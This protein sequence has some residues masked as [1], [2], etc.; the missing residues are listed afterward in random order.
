MLRSPHALLAVPALTY[1]EFL[2]LFLVIP[3]AGL[4]VLS[5]RRPA[6]WA[7]IRPWGVAIIVAIALLYTAPWDNYLIARGVWQYGEGTVTA[8]LGRAP[9]EEYLFIVLQPAIAALWLA[10]LPVRDGAGSLTVAP[11]SRVAGVLAGAG[12]GFVGAVALL[13]PA[14]FYLGAILLWAA[15]VLAIQWGFGWPF[16]WRHR[17]RVGFGVL[18]PTLYFSLADRI[19]IGMDIWTLSERYTTGIA[20]LGLPIEEAV[21]FL[22]TDLF[23]IQ[24]LVLYAW[25][26]DRWR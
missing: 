2:L 25:V 12:V 11:R 4:L 18:L 5:I 7:R 20:P 8:F 23:V 1:L 26:V 13:A 6:R 14:T 16:L 24:G 9:I 22:V 3:L 21:F 17:R 10:Q 15:P 19:A